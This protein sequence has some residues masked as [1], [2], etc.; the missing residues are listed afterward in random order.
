[1]ADMQTAQLKNQA[2][3][4]LRDVYGVRIAFSTYTKLSL[5]QVQRMI[6]LLAERDS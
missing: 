5:D 2:R 6:A 4:L 1:M 3:I